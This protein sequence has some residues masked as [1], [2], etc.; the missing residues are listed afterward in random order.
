MIRKKLIQTLSIDELIF[1]NEQR[2]YGDL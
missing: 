2:L 1:Q